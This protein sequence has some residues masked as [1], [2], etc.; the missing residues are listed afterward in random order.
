MFIVLFSFSVCL[1]QRFSEKFEERGKMGVRRQTS[2]REGHAG[3][4]VPQ[5]PESTRPKKWS[6]GV[7]V[8]RRAEVPA[9]RLRASDML[10]RE[11]Q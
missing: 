3:E 11:T 5:R 4:V 8:V 9:P 6:Q 7:L 2:L 10:M 1:K